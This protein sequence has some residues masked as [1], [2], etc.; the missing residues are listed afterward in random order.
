MRWF[1]SL[2]ASVALSIMLSGCLVSK[3]PLITAA[4]SDQPFPPHFSLG[5]DGNP[6]YSG[7]A[8]L[9]GDN[10]YIFTDR[11]GSKETLRF[12]KIAGNLYAAARPMIVQSTGELTGYQYGYIQISADGTRVFIHWPDCKA[13]EAANVEK[14]GVRIEKEDSDTLKECHIPSIE[15]LGTLINSYINDPKNA[16]HIKSRE[17]D[18]TFRIIKK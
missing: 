15:V 10:A 4:N 8:E 6:E 17:D 12:K 16:E 18:S 9:T 3:T 14:M 13:F 7:P 5:R 2:P 11:D 1:M